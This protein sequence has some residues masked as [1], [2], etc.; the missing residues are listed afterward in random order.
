LSIWKFPFKPSAKVIC[1]LAGMGIVVYYVSNSFTSS[2]LINIFSGAFMGT[3]VY[4]LM[5]LL[6]KEFSQ[7]ETKIIY[8]IKEKVLK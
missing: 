1:V 4:S 6:L 2:V 5:L 3:A 7:E 8:T